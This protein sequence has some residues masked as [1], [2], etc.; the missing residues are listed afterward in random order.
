MVLHLRGLAFAAPQLQVQVVRELDMI[1]PRN[2]CVVRHRAESDS[3]EKLSEII[4]DWVFDVGLAFSINSARSGRESKLR[5]ELRHNPM[6][7]LAAANLGSLLLQAGSLVE[8]EKW[9]RLALSM[10]DSLP[11]G[12]RR[13]RMELREIER[14]LHEEKDRWAETV[15]PKPNQPVADDVGPGI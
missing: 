13:V 3:P 5:D 12:G 11:D 1:L 15:L 9:L 7:A 10:G 6:D 2:R 14:R 8:A 4:M